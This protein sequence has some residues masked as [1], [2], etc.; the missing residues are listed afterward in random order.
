MIET[1]A[2]SAAVF[3]MGP[4]EF[5]ARLFNPLCWRCS[6]LGRNVR[7]AAAYE[8]SLSVMVC[9]WRAFLLPQEPCQQ[10]PRSLHVPV[11]LHDVDE[12][13]SFLIESA[14]Q[15]AFF[16]V[17]GGH[18]LGEMPYVMARGLFS[19]QAA[20]V[21]GAKVTGPASDRDNTALEQHFLDQ[22]QAQRKRK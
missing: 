1:L 18:D 8:S 20:G 10:L 4:W 7:L 11:S 17:D 16:T 14:P 12:H 3:R 5:S 19:L 9:L 15:T 6:T 2:S 13:I 22:T 21:I